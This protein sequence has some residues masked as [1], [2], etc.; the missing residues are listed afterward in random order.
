[1]NYEP[2]DL[3]DYI[4]TGEGGTAI[5]YN[6]LN[7]RTLAKLFTPGYSIES[8]EREFRINRVVY[9]TGLPTPEPIR[10]ITDGTRFGAEYELIHG[11]R[12]FTRIISQ[13]PEM[14]EPLSKRFAQLTLQLHA[15]PADTENLPDMREMVRYWLVRHENFPEDLRTQLLATLDT[16]P[17]NHTCL[18]GDLH[19]GNI[20][21]DGT[22]DLWIDV[23]DFA[24]GNPGWDLAMMYY[25]AQN[26]T[27][28][29]ADQIF[30]LDNATL[31]KHW[32][33]FARNYWNTDSPE[34]LAAEVKKLNPYLAL[35]LF[36]LISKLHNGKAPFHPGVLGLIRKLL[37]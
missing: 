11:K 27:P 21:T 36:F 30:H 7:G 37:S 24:Y 15:T 13:E 5:T 4:Q 8:I 9:D 20:I 18:H 32:D 28:E 19:I 2:I 25:S 35:K 29:R 34:E 12:S 17:D 1:M 26:L 6:H 31:Q 16:L 14:L 23:G 22:R 10:L 33:I 3:K